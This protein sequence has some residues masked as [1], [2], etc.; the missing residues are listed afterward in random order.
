MRRLPPIAERLASESDG[1]LSADRDVDLLL[2]VAVEIPED[3]AVGSVGVVFPTFKYGSHVLTPR[4]LDLRAY[5]NARRTDQQD[6]G[7]HRPIPA[8]GLSP[9]W[10]ASAASPFA[11]R[12]AVCT[13]RRRGSSS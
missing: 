13:L 10:R 7:P 3:H 5:T 6:G 2:I 1:V 11:P 8:H 12:P 4:I 9:P